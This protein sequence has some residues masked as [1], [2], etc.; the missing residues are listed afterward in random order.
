MAA[1]ND[2]QENGWVE[3][4]EIND[5]TCEVRQ[6]RLNWLGHIIRR[7]CVN[8]CFTALWWT[9]EGRR[10]R[11]SPKTTWRR[12]VEKEQNKAGWKS[13]PK[14]LHKTESVDQTVWRPYAPTGTMRLE[15]DECL[16]HTKSKATLVFTFL[17]ANAKYANY[18]FLHFSLLLR[19]H[20][21]FFRNSQGNLQTK[22]AN[23]P[24]KLCE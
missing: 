7:E 10:E 16:L 2:R 13:W 11:G 17:S 1:Q 12:T 18:N 4:A 23:K 8:D 19:Q 14:R 6:R 15:D 9:T 21:S 20:Y 3:L 5:I 22:Q 24:T